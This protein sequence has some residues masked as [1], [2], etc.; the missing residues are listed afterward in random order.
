MGQIANPFFWLFFYI[1]IPGISIF[2]FLASFLLIQHKNTLRLLEPLPYRQTEK[3]LK[4][5]GWDG[6]C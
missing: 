2:V 3:Y 5:T 6:D 1:A 4:K